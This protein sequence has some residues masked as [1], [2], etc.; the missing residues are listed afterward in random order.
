MSV[1]MWR[2][3]TGVENIPVTSRVN[4]PFQLSVSAPANAT[5]PLSRFAEIIPQSLFSRHGLYLGA[6]MA[7]L[8]RCL[9]YALVCTLLQ[10]FVTIRGLL[11]G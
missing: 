8:T 3:H 10:E 1:A 7:G 9:M 2:R 4:P 11:L 5:N 6:K